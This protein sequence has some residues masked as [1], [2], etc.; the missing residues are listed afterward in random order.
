[1]HKLNLQLQ[2]LK[3][4]EVLNLNS[5]QLAYIG[6]TVYD[7]FV[8]TRLI[9]KSNKNVQALHKDAC[10]IVNCAAQSGAL[11]RIEEGLTQ[12]EKGVVRRGRNAHA[13]PPK[14]ADPADYARA[15]GLEALIGFLYLS[16]QP[17][18]LSS[19]MEQILA[20]EGEEPCQG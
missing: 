10:S 14:N 15:T 1:M 7:L 20:G 16:G 6:D 2:P 18:R 17:E 19:L 12:D 4:E 8:R 3:R 9:G 11:L 13:R 5:L